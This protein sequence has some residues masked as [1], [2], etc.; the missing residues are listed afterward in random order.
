MT[1]ITAMLDVSLVLAAARELILRSSKTDLF[2]GIAS[3]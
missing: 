2:N 1:S 3:S